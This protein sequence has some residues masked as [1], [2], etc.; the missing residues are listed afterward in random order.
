MRSLKGHLLIAAPELDTPF[1]Q[2]TVILMLSHDENGA[3]GLV[4]NQPTEVTIA[5]IAGEAFH[6]TSDWQKSVDRGGPVSGPLIMIHTIAEFAEDTVIPGVSTTM[7]VE[8]LE[9]LIRRKPEPSRVVA[10][11]SGWGPGQLEGEF[12]WASWLTLP[13]TPEYIF[14][15]EANGDLWEVVLKAARTST[16]ASF[17]RVR[18]VPADPTFN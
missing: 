5:D 4:L 9:I 13:A 14:W 15:D 1:F 16:L 7:E 10:N 6:D 17:L 18:E 11:Y 3:M 2:R 8:A 12:G